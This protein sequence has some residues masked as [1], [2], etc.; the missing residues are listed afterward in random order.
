[1][2]LRLSQIIPTEIYTLY[3]GER[4]EM[5]L[6]NDGDNSLMVPE[7]LFAG[8]SYFTSGTIVNVQTLSSVIRGCQVMVSRAVSTVNDTYRLVCLYE[9]SPSALSTYQIRIF[10]LTYQL[11]NG[12][13]KT[14]KLALAATL[15]QTFPAYLDFY[16][17]T[18]GQTDSFLAVGYKTI[19]STGSPLMAF[20]FAKFVWK[21]D[22][23][24]VADDRSSINGIKYV[25]GYFNFSW[26]T[27]VVCN[28]RDGISYNESF[29]FFNQLDNTQ[30]YSSQN[31][32]SDL[33]LIYNYDAQ[34][35]VITMRKLEHY[36]QG[37]ASNGNLL[38]RHIYDFEFI[39]SANCIVLACH[40]LQIN[41][42]C[43]PVI[44][45]L[46]YDPTPLQDSTGKV[47]ND[48]VFNRY[49]NP[50]FLEGPNTFLS[51]NIGYR[52]TAQSVFKMGTN[53]GSGS[54]NSTVLNTYVLIR[55]DTIAREITY[56]FYGCFQNQVYTLWDSIDQK[57]YIPSDINSRFYLTKYIQG[58]PFSSA[59]IIRDNLVRYSLFFGF[60]SDGL[61][62]KINPYRTTAFD[63]EAI[64]ML[65][66]VQPIHKGNSAWFYTDYQYASS[67]FTN[68]PV[69]ATQSLGA[70]MLFSMT[71]D[72]PFSYVL[73]STVPVDKSY[74]ETF[75]LTDVN[76]PKVAPYK[77]NKYSIHTVRVT[78]IN[79]TLNLVNV[80]TQPQ[81]L[82]MQSG[83]F[84][85][86]P[87]K[88]TSLVGSNL[89]LSYISSNLTS[90][91]QLFFTSNNIRTVKFVRLQDDFPDIITVDVTY[92]TTLGGVGYDS[93]KKLIGFMSC[94]ETVDKKDNFTTRECAVFAVSAVITKADIVAVRE[95]YDSKVV[96]V[97]CNNLQDNK[98]YLLIGNIAE[99]KMFEDINYVVSE[100][101]KSTITMVESDGKAVIVAINFESATNKQPAF[102]VTVVSTKTGISYKDSVP[103]NSLSQLTTPS[104]GRIMSLGSTVIFYYYSKFQTKVVSI[105][106]YKFSFT[107]STSTFS[108]T[109]LEESETR[110]YTNIQ[111]P[112]SCLT[113]TFYL[114]YSK[115]DDPNAV[116]NQSYDFFPGEVY[117]SRKSFYTSLKVMMS[118]LKLNKIR[119]LICHNPEL[120]MVTIYGERKNDAGAITSVLAVYSLDRECRSRLFQI[121]ERPQ[122]FKS[123]DVTEVYQPIGSASPEPTLYF[124]LTQLSGQRET[125][126][127]QRSDFMQSVYLEANFTESSLLT[128]RLGN[129]VSS[130]NIN[131]VLQPKT[132]QPVAFDQ[133]PQRAYQQ[134]IELSLTP[135]ILQH[136]YGDIVS[137]TV[138]SNLSYFDKIIRKRVGVVAEY[139]VSMDIWRKPEK[140]R[141]QIVVL[142]D[143]MVVFSDK[144]C[145]LVIYTNFIYTTNLKVNSNPL[146]CMQIDNI[147]IL[148]MKNDSTL[149][150][151][152]VEDYKLKNSYY[153]YKTKTSASER[154]VAY[155]SSSGMSTMV[156]FSRTKNP[157]YA[158]GKKITNMGGSPVPVLLSF[159]IYTTDT[160]D[161]MV[162]VANTTLVG[163]VPTMYFTTVSTRV[164]EPGVTFREASILDCSSFESYLS[165]AVPFHGMFCFGANDEHYLIDFRS[166]FLD[167]KSFLSVERF[168]QTGIYSM[169]GNKLNCYMPDYYTISC[170][171]LPLNYGAT[172]TTF[173]LKRSSS[174]NPDCNPSYSFCGGL[175]KNP[176]FDIYP[177]GVPSKIAFTTDYLIA[178]VSSA[179][180]RAGKSIGMVYKTGSGKVY[181]GVDLGLTPLSE[182]GLSRHPTN[183]SRFLVLD[184]SNFTIRMFD[185]AEM[186][187]L[188]NSVNYTEVNG[189]IILSSLT[190][191][192]N[193]LILRS[194]FLG[195][196]EIQTTKPPPPP[197]QQQSFFAKYWFYM[198]C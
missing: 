49:E 11:I 42:T 57:S 26:T 77:K 23:Y 96:M 65:V 55:F 1:M 174:S 166:H 157:I 176:D 178:F 86:I 182:M 31:E 116:P 173:I 43:Q 165:D 111:S 40:N 194:T 29:F 72:P 164:L 195:G 53:G 168:T 25:A 45:R 91:P 16:L 44:V 158:V 70:N 122:E 109:Y 108:S 89:S 7:S 148:D 62:R 81:A 50:T 196:G 193:P 175:S 110:L 118:E 185:V 170:S 10:D 189:S 22:S 121:Y 143:F 107:D 144:D 2:Q 192:S 113:S 63:E 169:A 12:Q 19:T 186:K 76:R 151:F 82:T 103:A 78:V 155:I 66:A 191:I 51:S 61:M 83:S 112:S 124:Y 88:S 187:F 27:T 67:F 60:Y 47:T 188:F 32:N 3:Y 56:S 52:I 132:T 161:I 24:V 119:Q 99:K 48:Y 128:F 85:F 54:F 197:Q 84:S 138:T 102:M 162:G 17:Y 41:E 117:R 184:S 131:V 98:L 20:A 4:R 105:S 87:L 150:I 37:P 28:S 36:F 95:S 172:L 134:G 145:L 163:G 104:E 135:D 6:G 73:P 8:N 64:K 179:N 153:N 100:S 181:T 14:P 123:V 177:E 147:N 198:A 35:R 183:N 159:N 38:S 33:F 136:V 74:I 149:H 75:Y 180:I 18:M 46:T 120:D 80:T 139:N 39:D 21:V 5:G 115:S 59:S 130:K 127:I 154:L 171:I 140:T 93:K 167:N 106:K 146:T 160:D 94:N 68:P 71:N 129:S 126:R 133:S 156:Q 190:Q 101:N 79:S 9:P 30:S 58:S 90:Q 69:Y 152:Y 15:T 141:G 97:V 13:Y 114:L 137:I 92:F 34:K 142:Q 125:V